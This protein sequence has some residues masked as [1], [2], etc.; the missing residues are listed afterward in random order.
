MSAAT[1]QVIDDALNA[2]PSQFHSLMD[3]DEDVLLGLKPPKGLLLQDYDDD[4]CKA[5]D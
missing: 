5:P 2:L 1:C 4:A 3:E